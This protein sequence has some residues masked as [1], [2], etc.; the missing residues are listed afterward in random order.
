MTQSTSAFTLTA[1]S[2]EDLLAVV[3]VVLGFVPSD[4]VAMLTFGARQPFHARVDMAD[5]E[6]DLPDLVASLLDP[7]VQHR[8]RQVVFVVYSADARLARTAGRALVHAFEESGIEVI[9]VLRADGE[10]WF[11]LAGPPDGV[12]E[13]GR[14]YDVSAH[15]FLAQ[16]V[17][18]G[19]VT[20]A[21]R[22]DLAAMLDPE[23]EAVR[24]V[25]RLLGAQGPP[26]APEW[27]RDTVARHV[28]DGTTPEVV[29]TARLLEAIADEP[30][31][32]AAWGLMTRAT[33]RDHVRL[34]TDVVRRAPDTVVSAPA[35]LLGFAAWL[36]GHGALAWCAIDRCLEVDPDHR[37]ANFLAQAL[38]RAVPPSAWDDPGAG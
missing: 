1:R 38:S 13:L 24:K 23:P 10:R 30:A 33:S 15:P 31:R 9:E 28:T 21:S 29:D 2:P 3:P 5:D 26:P 11:P 20:H 34:W 22:D 4:S 32:D 35:A 25:S 8:V 17:L 12:Q 36:A 19:Q 37:L 6:D 27:V 14:P 16:S 7:A 18:N